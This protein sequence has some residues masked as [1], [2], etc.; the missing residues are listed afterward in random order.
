MHGFWLNRLI[1]SRVRQDSGTLVNGSIN[2]QHVFIV[3]QSSGLYNVT[4]K[5]HKVVVE[6]QGA[7]EVKPK[8]HQTKVINKR[9]GNHEDGLICKSIHDRYTSHEDVN[10]ML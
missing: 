8:G 1:A 10:K 7:Q 2:T 4:T 3:Q 9:L 6:D 5:K